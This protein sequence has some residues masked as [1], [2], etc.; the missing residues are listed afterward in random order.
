MLYKAIACFLFTT[1]LTACYLEGS[2]CS[3]PFCLTVATDF[4]DHNCSYD[5]D[6][7][8]KL[9][10]PDADSIRFLAR[11]A[12][13]SAREFPSS[14]S[15]TATLQN[16]AAPVVWNETLF[17]AADRQA[18]DMASN[19]FVDTLGSDGVGVDIRVNE[20]DGSFT[21]V[22]QLVAGGFSESSTLI[23]EWLANPVDCRRVLNREVTSF[24]MACRYDRNSDFGTYWSLV[25][26]TN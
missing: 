26:G 6:R 22:N 8:F 25:L 17:S 2:S 19:N 20:V 9:R 7:E 16:S 5:C 15:C 18:R 10:C 24:A 1:T 21:G 4:D 12:I 11:S 13:N 23:N 14:T 3:G